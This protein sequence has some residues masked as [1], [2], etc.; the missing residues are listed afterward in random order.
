MNS[1]RQIITEENIYPHPQA[2]FISINGKRIGQIL[3]IG[4]FGDWTYNDN[5]DYPDPCS[6]RGGIT[7]TRESALEKLIE[8]YAPKL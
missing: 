2:F 1:N 4:R 7:K 6:T 3:A 5:I 8:K